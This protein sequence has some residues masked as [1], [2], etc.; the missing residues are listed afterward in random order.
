MGESRLFHNLLWLLALVLIV[1]A[2]AV[3]WKRGPAL[4]TAS[5][6][7]A[8]VRVF[9]K[10]APAV[11]SISAEPL[12]ERPELGIW[13]RGGAPW[14]EE[15]F[16]NFFGQ[17]SKTSALNLGTGIIVDPRGFIITNEHVVNNTASI[18]ITLADGNTAAGEV[19]GLDPSLDLA[20]IKI[21][22]DRDLPYLEM[23]RSDDLMIGEPVV[24]IGN[25]LGLGHSC[26]SGIVSSLH[27]SVQ[28]GGR[29]YQDLVQIDA[30]VNPGNSG[31]PLLNIRGQ[32]IG[33]T[34]ALN[35]EAQGIGFAIPI[36]RAKRAVDD[37][38]QYHYIPS[39]WLGVSVEN[40]RPSGGPGLIG[41]EGA[42]VSRLEEKSPASRSLK[43]GDIIQS[44]DGEMVRGVEDF[45]GH[46]RRL[47]VGQT[48][49]LSILRDGETQKV[50]LQ[51][52]VFPERLAEEW[53]FYRVGVTVEEANI[54]F[55]DRLGRIQVRPGTFVSDVALSSP[56]MAVGL[57]PGD[58][59]LWLNREEVKGLDDFRRAVSRL[60]DRDSLF[61]R[62]QREGYPLFV[63]I[64]LRMSGERW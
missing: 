15:F 47:T 1:A 43:P 2:M 9:R 8:V 7:T 59:L 42:V 21:E 38:I 32:L 4:F 6:E 22:V 13:S 45:V 16:R 33:I 5:R 52:E 18:R 49:R 20:V 28:A 57:Q 62:L 40:L 23:G 44:W 25:P 56:A 19:W 3:A 29:V 26:T 53:F 36:S 51:A 24:V 31:G 50:K 54:R 55:R 61:V 35:A 37:L 48:V 30:A 60:R 39:A 17:G 58:L 64:P 46:A 14:A 12:P 34:S 41:E 27:R 11:V 63:S 10:A